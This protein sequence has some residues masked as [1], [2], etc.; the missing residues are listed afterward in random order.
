MES[1]ATLNPTTYSQRTAG[2]HL[3]SDDG[4]TLGEYAVVLTAITVTIL[5][6]VALLATSIG[7]HI[8]QIARLVVSA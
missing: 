7:H 5:L 1:S 4:Q 8:V 3:A 6:A 2:A